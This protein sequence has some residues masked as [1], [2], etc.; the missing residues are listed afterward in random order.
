[1]QQDEFIKLFIST[2]YSAGA[3]VLSF[4]FTFFY[5][6]IEFNICSCTVCFCFIVMLSL[7]SIYSSWLPKLREHLSPILPNTF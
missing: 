1:M 5:Y 2:L 4:H 7:M 6:G 3:D